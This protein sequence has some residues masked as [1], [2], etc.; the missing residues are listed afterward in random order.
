MAVPSVGVVLHNPHRR[1]A[2][3]GQLFQ[4]VDR[5]H[6]ESLLVQWVGVSGVAVLI[7]WRFQEAHSWH[8]PGGSRAEEIV[9]VV[10]WVGRTGVPNLR[11][12]RS[13]GRRRTLPAPTTSD[14]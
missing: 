14:E 12:Q 6:Q 11:T 7:G 4:K 1:A 3:G 8:I 5:I 10:L 13:P 9:P 2:P